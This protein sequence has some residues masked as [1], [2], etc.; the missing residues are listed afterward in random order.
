MRAAQH[1]HL[2]GSAVAVVGVWDPF[3]PTHKLLLED[4]RDR[5]LA[6]G[7]TSVVVLIDPP[8]GAAGGFHV[9]YGM[10]DWPVYDSVGARVCLIRDLGVDCVLCMRFRKRDFD[11]TAAQFLDAV[12]TRVELEELWLGAVQLLGPGSR[13]A[14]PAVAEYAD[15]HGFRLTILPRA[16]VGTY[17]IRS[18]LAAGRLAD[19]IDI[20]GRPPIWGAPRSGALR[21][22]WRPGAY[23]AVGLERPGAVAHG[24][25][26]E[27]TLTPEP[28]RPSRLIWPR[29]DIHYLAFV[30]GPADV[31]AIERT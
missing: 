15:R 29:P 23:R 8:P 21:L 31:H 28:G 26:L 4:L 25:E 24:A 16:P 10:P 6:S 11:A 27:V 9:R 17:D 13:G 19:A 12:R 7:C 1:G 20:V 22:S 3:L 14:R 18:L 2:T 5:A 30:S